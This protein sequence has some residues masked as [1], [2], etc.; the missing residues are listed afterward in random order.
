MPKA[1]KRKTYSDEEAGKDEG[2]GPVTGDRVGR[3]EED[4]TA[5]QARLA[6]ALKGI[7]TGMRALPRARILSRL[8]DT[9]G[10]PNRMHLCKLL[11]MP[12]NP[13]PQLSVKYLLKAVDDGTNL[14]LVVMDPLCQER[15]IGF[16]GDH[17]LLKRARVPK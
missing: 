6:G 9:L 12:Y 8:F 17:E 16:F 3:E 13:D 4:A 14:D 11:D 5:K 7:L 2:S 1:E 10:K 15:L